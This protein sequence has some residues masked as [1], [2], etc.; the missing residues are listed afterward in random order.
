MHLVIRLAVTHGVRERVG[1]C[2]AGGRGLERGLESLK[3]K[4]EGVFKVEGVLIRWHDMS[5]LVVQ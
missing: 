4:V 1:V 2:L 3:L 5:L